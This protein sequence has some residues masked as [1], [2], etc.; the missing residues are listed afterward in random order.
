MNE[1]NRVLTQ[2]RYVDQWNLIK[3]P[4]MNPHIYVST[5]YHQRHQDHLSNDKRMVFQHRVLGQ[6]DGHMQKM[7]ALTYYCVQKN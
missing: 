2:H 4:E 1:A 5:A 3:S 6:M 7:K